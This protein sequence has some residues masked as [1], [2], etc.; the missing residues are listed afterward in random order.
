MRIRIGT[1]GSRL[2]R[3]Q[4]DYIARLLVE[5]YP[6][7]KVE[8][9][10]FTTK[11]DKILD[12]AL[13]SIGGKGLF[14]EELERAL[15]DGDID[16]AV[17]SL[18]DL[19]VENPAGLTV[20]AI[21][22]RAPVEDVLVTR[23]G[24]SLVDLPDRAVIGT[25]SL[26]RAAQIKA[27]RPDVSLIDIRGNVPTRI[28]KAR[29]EDGPYDATILAQAGVERLG[30]LDDGMQVLPLDVM[31]PA[32][33]QGAIGVQCRDDDASQRV[34]GA[35]THDDTRTA[36]TAERLFLSALGGGC[37]VPVASYG[38]VD[39]DSLHLQGRVGS[40]DGGTVIHVEGASTISD[41]SNLAASL[42]QQAIEQGAAA[43]LAEV[44]G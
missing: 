38:T 12:K 1:R 28:D 32:P 27:I 17:H 14:T 2:A 42:A 5:Q 31:L 16:C 19:P 6:S 9:V 18:K 10:V 24:G 34:F 8:I 26:R 39:G 36:V 15:L 40:P 25:S 3:W 21:P 35:L 22:V 4:T 20:G 13:P 30:L 44:R 23:D 43:I 41:F 37:A 11:G 33:G 7:A 29:A